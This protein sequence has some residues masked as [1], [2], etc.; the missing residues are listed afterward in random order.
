M[1][2]PSRV[3]PLTGRNRAGA[4]RVRRAC[5]VETLLKCRWQLLALLPSPGCEGAPL[6]GG[7]SCRGSLV[8]VVFP[9]FFPSPEEA[10][11]R[12]KA[13]LPG[14]RR[15]QTHAPASVGWKI[16]VTVNLFTPA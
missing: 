10:Q 13:R 4:Q 1:A 12:Q 5:W 7:A 14:C 9:V 2:P 3:P 6:V 16:G 11:A 8:P 15:W